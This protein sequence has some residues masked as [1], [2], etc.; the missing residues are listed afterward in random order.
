[1]GGHVYTGGTV[2]NVSGSPDGD[3]DLGALNLDGVNQG[4]PITGGSY[5]VTMNAN[6][7]ADAVWSWQNVSWSTASSGFGTT[8]GPGGATSG[9]VQ[10]R[11]TIGINAAPA[12]GFVF[13]HWNFS[14][15]AP[16]DVNNPNTTASLDNPGAHGFTAVYVLVPTPTPTP[17]PTPTPTPTPIPCQLISVDR[18]V[19]GDIIVDWT[20]CDGSPGS[21]NDTGGTPFGSGITVCQQVGSTSITAGSNFQTLGD[22]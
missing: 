5:N 12:S 1:V 4:V 6:H 20:N 14:N 3:S 9:V 10:K 19:N 15:S 2:V 7:T 16:A 13:D 22:C 21:I 8:T 11:A 17:A 18:D